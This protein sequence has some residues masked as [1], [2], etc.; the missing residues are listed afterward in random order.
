MSGNLEK[1]FPSR[2]PN[3]LAIIPVA[4]FESEWPSVLCLAEK[5][6]QCPESVAAFAY[7]ALVCPNPIVSNAVSAISAWNR[8]Y[9]SCRQQMSPFH[10]RWCKNSALEPIPNRVWSSFRPRRSPTCEMQSR[11]TFVPIFPSPSHWS[12][13]FLRRTQSPSHFRHFTNFSCAASVFPR[14]PARGAVRIGN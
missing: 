13:Y 11:Q 5:Q 10:R 6:L 4:P 3:R 14:L 7:F 9:Q 1:T 12:H 2:N 8:L